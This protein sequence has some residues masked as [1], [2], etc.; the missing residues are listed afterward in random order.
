MHYDADYFNWQKNIGAF[1]ALANRFLFAQYVGPDDRV[2]DLGCGGG[3]TLHDL[4]AKE[5][6]GVDIN[7]AARESAAGFG[8]QVYAAVEELPD[9]WATVVISNHALEH[10]TAPLDTLRALHAKVAPGGRLVLVVPHDLASEKWV[11]GDINQHLYTWNPMTLGNLVAAAGY[12]VVRVEVI[13]HCWWEDDVGLYKLLGER[14]FYLRCRLMAYLTRNYQLRV[15]ARR[16]ERDP[17]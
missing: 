16:P 15:V 14:L 4:P 9:R 8:L 1:G 2:V 13:R 7:S 10:V 17:A 12:D 5:K 6:A 3:F 11:P